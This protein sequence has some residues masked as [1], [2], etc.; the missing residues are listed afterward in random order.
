MSTMPAKPAKTRS[1]KPSVRTS[2]VRSSPTRSNGAAAAADGLSD[3]SDRAE[4]VEGAILPLQAGILVNLRAPS[5]DSLRCQDFLVLPGVDGAGKATA[6]IHPKT[7]VDEHT[8]TAL[9]KISA[10]VISKKGIAH[11]IKTLQRWK[12]KRR[13]HSTIRSQIGGYRQIQDL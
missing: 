10:A 8:A 6:T 1:E 3:H 7:S 9:A 5:S 12:G 2:P 11:L 13:F 4:A